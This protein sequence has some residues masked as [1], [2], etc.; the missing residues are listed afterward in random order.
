MIAVALMFCGISLIASLSASIA[1]YFVESDSND[2][3]RRIEMRLER[4]EQALKA[5]RTDRK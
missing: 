5:E 2:R 3:L 4:I 1:A